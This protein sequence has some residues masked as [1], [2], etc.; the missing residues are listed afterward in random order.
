INQEESQR[1]RKILQEIKELHIPQGFFLHGDVHGVHIFSDGSDITGIIDP[2]YAMSGDP[3]LDVAYTHYFLT[4]QERIH[5]N[6]GYGDVANDPAVSKYFL[7]IAIDKIKY[8]HSQG[9]KYRIPHAVAALK[10]VLDAG[11][12]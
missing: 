3:R 7:L 9:F 10:E 8:R 4:P 6:E 2:G 5:F 11:K 12:P 1:I